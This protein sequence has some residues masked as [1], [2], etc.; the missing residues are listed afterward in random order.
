M[1]CEHSA[2]KWKPASG[3]RS[4]SPVLT[5][6]ASSVSLPVLSSSP[7]SSFQVEF[8]EDFESCIDHV[9]AKF[10]EHDVF[11]VIRSVL[12]V[13]DYLHHYGIA[14]Q[15][16][17]YALSLSLSLSSPTWEHPLLLQRPRQRY[18]HHRLWHARSIHFPP[19][20]MFSQS[21]LIHSSD[22]PLP[23]AY[24]NETSDHCSLSTQ[25]LS[26]TF[27]SAATP[28]SCQWHHRPC[29]ANPLSD[30]SLPSI[31]SIIPPLRRFY[32]IPGLPLPPPPPPPTSISLPHL[33]KIG[34]LGQSGIVLWLASGLQTGLATLL[35]LGVARACKV[36]VD[37]MIR[38]RVQVPLQRRRRWR[39][40][41]V[42]LCLVL[43]NLFI[44]NRRFPGQK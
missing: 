26:S 27:S 24:I 25:L 21:K 36:V 3:N 40:R 37:G 31:H 28:I 12:D 14:H 16:F 15:D 8:H 35:L 30:V 13:V 5:T 1:P 41:K 4:A 42:R 18:R 39:W 34:I 32:A 6:A 43:L 7:H 11:T 10:T 44:E 9:L 23:H 29:P 20:I 19:S 33:D 2:V 22:N 38:I 17:K